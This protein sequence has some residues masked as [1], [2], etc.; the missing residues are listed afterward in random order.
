VTFNIDISALAI[1]IARTTVTANVDISALAGVTAGAI[2][3]TSG[4]ISALTRVTAGAIVTTSGNIPALTRVTAGA[5]VTTSGN[6]PA[7]TRVTAGAIAKICAGAGADCLPLPHIGARL[8]LVDVVASV[9][10]GVTLVRSTDTP[11]RRILWVHRD[12]AHAVAE[13]A[14]IRHALMIDLAV[15][16]DASR[17]GRVLALA[18]DTAGE[19]AG[20]KETAAIIGAR[21]SDILAL[22]FVAWQWDVK[23]RQCMITAAG[24]DTVE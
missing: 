19:A 15:V 20:H 17:P 5:I 23:D 4:N 16:A 10:G 13:V 3:T 22:V 11:L 18:A 12:L 1:V 8:I 14:T 2:V 6:I 7:L 9:V 24:K 21:A